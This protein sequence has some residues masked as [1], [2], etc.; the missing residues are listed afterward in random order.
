MYHT[1]THLICIPFHETVDSNLNTK[2]S[3]TEM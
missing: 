1:I 3:E 2:V